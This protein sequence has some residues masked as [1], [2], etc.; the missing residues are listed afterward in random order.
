MWIPAGEGH[1][2]L[3]A[4]N[5]R[6]R[7]ISGEIKKGR[8]G[9]EEARVTAEGGP[10][11]LPRGRAR[12]LVKDRPHPR[13][14]AAERGEPQSVEDRRGFRKPAMIVYTNKEQEK[15]KE[16]VNERGNRCGHPIQIPKLKG[17]RV[18][19]FATYLCGKQ[20]SF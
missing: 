5:R 13:R 4:I 16:L 18:Q 3:I 20:G 11:Q 2:P 15:T 6:L 7:M 14:R 9:K 17:G 8:R 12:V 10:G 19:R 1:V